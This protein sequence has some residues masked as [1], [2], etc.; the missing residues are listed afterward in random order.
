MKTDPS[1]FQTIIFK[2]HDSEA[3]IELNIWN[4]TLKL[5]TSLEI[6]LNCKLC[7][8]G[9]IIR[10]CTR[11]VL[12]TNATHRIVNHVSHDCYINIRKSFIVSDLIYC[13][14]VGLFPSNR[15]QFKLGK[16]NKTAALPE[17]NSLGPIDAIW[18]QKTGSTLAQVMACCLTAPSHYLNQCWL[19]ISKV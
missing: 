14:T 12:Q 2:H 7:F 9:H 4:D 19:I 3:T 6:T 16:V 1:K 13:K 18:R 5:V 10:L 11:V 8:G 15:C 17:I